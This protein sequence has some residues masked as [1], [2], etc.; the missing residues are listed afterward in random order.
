MSIVPGPLTGSKP[1]PP[2]TT[3]KPRS[4]KTNSMPRIRTVIALML[5][6]GSV[7]VEMAAPAANSTKKSYDNIVFQNHVAN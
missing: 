2:S 5:A 1:Q 6:D 3:R 4:G 7:Y